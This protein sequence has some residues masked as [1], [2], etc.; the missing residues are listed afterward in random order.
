MNGYLLILASESLTKGYKREL[1]IRG[2]VHDHE[3]KNTF[4]N[5]S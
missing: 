4:M 3:P 5:F 1:V 2:F